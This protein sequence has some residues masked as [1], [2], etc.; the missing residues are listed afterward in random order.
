MLSLVVTEYVFASYPDLPEGD[1]TRVRAAIVSTEGLAP[2][3]A[4]LG[5]GEVVRLGRGEELSG[6]R[7]KP[8]ILA[9]TFEALI[10]ATYLS[11]GVEAARTF[12]LGALGDRIESEA[13][14][15]EL[16]DPKGRLQELAARL[17]APVPNYRTSHT[18]PDHA[19]WWRAEVWIGPALLGRGEGVSR[20][21]A[22]RV[23]ALEACEQ[24]ATD[25]DGST[26]SGGA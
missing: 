12:V 4:A 25:R 24:L 21:H 11:A 1:L 20:K 14:R 26:G 22:E 5:V 6:G 2:V 16:R 3:A 18:G 17:G 15:S 23:A 8:S 19:R 9:D 7:A 10:G 13:S